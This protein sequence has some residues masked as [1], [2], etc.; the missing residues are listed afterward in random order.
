[1]ITKIKKAT[2]KKKLITIL[3]GILCLL[4][5]LAGILGIYQYKM[6][7]NNTAPILGDN[8]IEGEI[9]KNKTSKR[10][11]SADEVYE[12][13]DYKVGKRIDDVFTVNA[14]EGDL[15]QLKPKAYDPDGDKLT[16]TF[17]TPFD[18][19][20]R[21]LTHIGDEGRYVV[22]VNASDGETTT[23][24]KVL[25]VVKR[26][27]RPPVIDCPDDEL[28]F[29]EGEK[30]DL[31]C[32]VADEEN[33]PID[34]TVDGWKENL[35]FRTGYG[36][37]GEHRIFLK[38]ETPQ[39]KVT[40]YL[41]VT[42][43]NINRAPVFK[44]SYPNS[45]VGVETDII[46]L[47]TENIYDPDKDPVSTEFSHPFNKEGVWRT[48]K[49]D[50]GVRKVSVVASDGKESSKKEVTVKIERLNTKPVIESI[51][52]IEVHEGEKIVLPVEVKD[53]EGDNVKVDVTGF[54]NSTEYQTG[55]DDA[56]EY[57]ATIT[58]T[59]GDL[60]SKEVVSITVLDKNRPPVFV[61]P[62]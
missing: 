15:I 49:G 26:A 50:A 55:Y 41:N 14:T 23:S 21:W 24:E 54:M 37:A 57:T 22:A 46:K 60:T 1:M 30:V 58:A 29:K 10:T 48:E 45:I 47:P 11:P 42:V 20:G 4:I 59:D 19:R 31:N 43:E 62:G 56:G 8:S 38:A 51:P 16:Y 18:E 52:S 39:H 27:N 32:R 28:R 12:E 7:L 5:V 61:T 33:D 2:G 6:G 53:K 9:V 3:T 35:K 44:E 34:F 40:K 13:K 36:E 17:G 25:V